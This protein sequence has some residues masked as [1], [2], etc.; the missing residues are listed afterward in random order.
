MNAMNSNAFFQDSANPSSKLIFRMEMPGRLI[1]WNQVLGFGHWQRK[2]MKDQL[3][4]DFLFALRLSGIDSSTKTISV[5]NTTSIYAD[6]LE[7]YR[8]MLQTRSALRRNK[9]KLA[10]AKKKG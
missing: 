7:S 2:K 1:S 5:K 8:M 3:A 6:T 10:K 4:K 9:R